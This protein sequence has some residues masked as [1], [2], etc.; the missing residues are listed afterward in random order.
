MTTALSQHDFIDFM[1]NHM[2][3]V[4]PGVTHAK[5]DDLTYEFSLD[6]DKKV[7]IYL[8]NA[9]DNY[10]R[11][12]DINTATHFLNTQ[13][14]V[15]KMMRGE[16]G[17]VDLSCV[18]PVI[19]NKGFANGAEVKAEEAG[20]DD[21]MVRDELSV[22]FDVVY[23]EDA[24]GFVV[25]VTKNRLG[26]IEVEDFVDTAFE[27]LKKQGWVEPIES[28]DIGDFATIHFFHEADKQYQAQFMVKELYEEHLGDYFHFAFPTRDDA[29][30]MQ[31][32]K[33]PDEHLE[34]AG[35]LAIRF[36]T[37]AVNMYQTLPNPLSHVL[38]A[39]G[40]KGV[41]TLA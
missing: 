38:H 41:R 28:L 9:W 29:I 15:F 37:T 5:V 1:L 7:Q 4:V 39:G 36:K 16:L 40:H 20:L 2:Q 18:F 3:L 19:R 34:M 6:E 31:F 35:E 30:V 25:F 17:D 14:K 24:P 33:N 26:E 11:T 27:N 13:A 32:H 8:G 22:T 21:V 12:G 23:V 10:Q